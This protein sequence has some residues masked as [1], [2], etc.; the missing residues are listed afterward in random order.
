[1]SLWMFWLIIGIVLLIAEMMT[2]TFYLL[3][4]GI[5]A[6]TACVIALA[7]PS[8]LG[9]QVLV[10]GIVAVVLTVF[11]KPLT[12]HVHKG[13]GFTDTVDLLVGKI[14]EVQERIPQAGIGIVKVGSET[15]SAVSD[16][17]LEQGDRVKIIGRKTTLLQVEKWGG[18]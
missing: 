9:L 2:F 8:T 15:W 13:R 5:G 3:W 17:V 7:L 16:E 4:L 14:G 11:T 6:L 1:M 10:A 12:K 18:E